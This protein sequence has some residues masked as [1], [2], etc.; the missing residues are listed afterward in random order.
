VRARLVAAD[1]TENQKLVRAFA[2]KRSRIPRWL[3][4]FLAFSSFAMIF[5]GARF[6]ETI[7]PLFISMLSLS[8]ASSIGATW[9][10]ARTSDPI[11]AMRKSVK[12]A[13][14]RAVFPLLTLSRAERI[15]CDTLLLLS[16]SPVDSDAQMMEDILRQLNA[17]VDNSRQIDGQRDRILAA[18]GTNGT[19][20]LEEERAGLARQIANE[21]DALVRQDLQ[22]SLEMCES[23]LED[24]RALERSLKRLD[25]QH[26]VVLQTLASVH[27][28]LARKQVAPTP[29][30]APDL[31]EIQQ[32]VTRINVQTQA[33]EKAVQE[34]MAVSTE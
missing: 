25:A 33:V 15:Y 18:I 6:A 4:L 29:L 3:P 26:Q 11:P 17:L 24:A 28:S 20:D 27:S 10:M 12:N 8:F 30:A 23:R 31:A 16:D 34:V 21:D 13:E 32:A 14:L 19:A 9:M 5:L 22:Q 7:Q 1:T 2:T